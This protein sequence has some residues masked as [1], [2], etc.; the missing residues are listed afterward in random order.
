ML[1]ET[2]HILIVDDDDRI[3]AMLSD[4]LR[5]RGM[6]VSQAANGAQLMVAMRGANVDLIL[7]DVMLPGD[8]GFMLCRRLRAHSEVAIILLTAIN[9]TADR[10]AGLELGADDY[11]AKPFDPSELLARVRA[12]LRRRTA[13]AQAQNRDRTVYRFEGWT[14]DPRRRTL[15]SSKNVLVDL[16]SGEFDLLLAFLEH[17][18]QVLSRDRLLDLARGRTSQ[19]FD[20]SIDVQISRLRRK[21]EEAPAEPALIKTIRNEGYLFAAEVTSIRAERHA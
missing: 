21:L 14:L 18:Q 9:E 6:L 20:R 11:V 15:R 7:L 16:T 13:L 1:P 8:D 5:A 3:R 19:V 12:V 10:V 4:F 17:P 2:P